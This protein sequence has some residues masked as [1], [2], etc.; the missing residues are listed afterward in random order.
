MKLSSILLISLFSVT[1]AT[2]AQSPSNGDVTNGGITTSTDP[3]KAAEVEKKAQEIQSRQQ[4]AQQDSSGTSAQSQTSKT[5]KHAKRKSGK[6]RATKS[7]VRLVLVRAPALAQAPTPRLPN[8]APAEA[9]Q[10]RA[11]AVAA[12]TALPR[13]AGFLR[14]QK[15]SKKGRYSGSIT[16]ATRNRETML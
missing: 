6:K 8:Q 5:K 15:Y 14:L 3:A 1:S 13:R 12:V 7:Q 11:P 9:K 2:F 4:Q 16:S 10:A